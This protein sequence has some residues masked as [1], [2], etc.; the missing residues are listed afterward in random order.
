MSN[1]T[2][3]TV[4]LNV[5]NL[6]TMLA[7]YQD[8]IGLTVHQR[9]GSRAH[10]GVG[11]QD[12]LV[13]TETPDKKRVRS[14]TGLYHFAILVPTRVQLAKSLKRLAE[15][16][17]RIQGL[18]DHH[19][20]EAI[21][22]ADPEG[23]GIEIY[24]DRARET[25]YTNGQ[26]RMDTLALD[27]ND[28]MRTLSTEDAE[29]EGLP[30]GTIMGHIHLHV[31][32]VPQAEAFYRTI[33]GMDVLMNMGSATFMSYDGYHHH[34]GANIWGGRQLPAGQE[35]GLDKYDLHIRDATRL[36]AIL[37]QLDANDIAITPVDEGYRVQDPSLNSV[38]IRSA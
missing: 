35:L 34:V 20:S 18:S 9:V 16:Q 28:L 27:V 3:G 25:W 32:S 33:L 4:Y 22:L 19:V 6:E 38:V 14:A 30:V 36:D 11:Q 31:A 24:H 26:L 15:T 10:L 29:W 12:I 17:T 7:F 8:I 1:F 23:N 13:L 5:A 2:I 21:Y 37:G